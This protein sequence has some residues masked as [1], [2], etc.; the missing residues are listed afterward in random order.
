MLK[1]EKS[2]AELRIKET[3]SLRE[4]QT[5]RQKGLEDENFNL[6]NNNQSLTNILNQKNFELEEIKKRL[7]Q[8]AEENS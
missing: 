8:V 1:S 5:L 7:Q 3:S 2:M 4:S 6:K